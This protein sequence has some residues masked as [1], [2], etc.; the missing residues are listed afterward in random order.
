MS[1]ELTIALLAGVVL[2]AS[3][4]RAG[5]CTVKAVAEIM[6]SAKAHFIWSF[7]KASLWT[8]AILG[9]AAVFG[10]DIDL[11]HRPVQAQA[12]LGGAIFGIG[13]GLNGT[14]SFSTLARLTEGHLAM[15]FTLALWR[16]CPCL[17]SRDQPP[18]FLRF[19]CCR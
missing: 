11:A 15:L 10:L 13:A 12:I 6:T 14:C 1:P 5:L 8:T 18:L 4:H 9:W 3:A 7:I 19:F 17:S 2:G 16:S